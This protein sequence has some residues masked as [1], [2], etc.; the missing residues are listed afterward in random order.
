MCWVYEKKKIKVSIRSS[1]H[2]C[3]IYIACVVAEEIATSHSAAQ[4]TSGSSFALLCLCIITFDATFWLLARCK[5][6][7]KSIGKEYFPKV[8]EQY[9][10][11]VSFSSSHSQSRFRIYR[12][13]FELLFGWY[14][15]VQVVVAGNSSDSI[16]SGGTMAEKSSSKRSDASTSAIF[17][18]WTLSVFFLFFFP[19][20]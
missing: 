11:P 15:I 18:N 1:S 2:K 8:E 12:E 14:R 5:R 7:R 3:Y 10:S 16:G 19:R 9:F 6:K 4:H 13:T 17:E 20:L